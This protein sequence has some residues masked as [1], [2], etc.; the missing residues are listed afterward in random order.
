M[1]RSWFH[2]ISRCDFISGNICTWDSIRLQ[3]YFTYFIIYRIKP[4]EIARQHGELIT[5]TYIIADE[6][7]EVLIA[8]SEVYR[9]G[10]ELHEF[11]INAMISNQSFTEM[12][13]VFQNV[14]ADLSASKS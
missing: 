3:P 14:F 6:Y 7:V 5:A 2:G 11:A 10:V 4:S 12:T 13:T 8:V 9:Q 1:K